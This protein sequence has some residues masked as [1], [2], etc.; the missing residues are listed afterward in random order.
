M[1]GILGVI[2]VI[3]MILLNYGLAKLI[4]TKSIKYYYITQDIEN[5][6]LYLK[7]FIKSIFLPI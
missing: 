3:M 7:G 6:L 4:K 1:L 2:I 5:S